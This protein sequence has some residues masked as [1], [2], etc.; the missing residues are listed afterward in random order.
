MKLVV[1][2][3]GQCGSQIADEFARLNGR[4]RTQRGIEIVTG[5][6]AVNTDAA[7]LSGL[8]NIRPYGSRRHISCGQPEIC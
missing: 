8:A 1:I 4:A 5:I 3:L 6:F 7:D 2:G